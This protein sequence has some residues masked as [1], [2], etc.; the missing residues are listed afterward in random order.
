[1]ETSKLQQS[2]LGCLLGT[3]VSDALG[4]PYEGLNPR[5]AARIFGSPDR[6]HFF[7]GRGMV[8][9][10][11]E[12]ACFTAK[13]LIASRIDPVGFERSLARSLRWWLASIPAGVG[14]ATAMAIFKMWVGFGPDKSGVFSAGNGPAMRSP[15]L[16]VVF[17]DNSELMKDYVKRSTRLTH[18]DPKAY[19]GALCAAMAAAISAKGKQV[20]PSEFFSSIQNLYSPE[21][22]DNFISLIKQACQSAENNDLPPKSAAPM[23]L[24]AI[25]CIPFPV[26]FKHGCAISRIFRVAFRKS[27]RREATRIRLR[28]F[29]A[30]SSA[31]ESESKAFLQNGSLVFGNGQE[32]WIGWKSSLRH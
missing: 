22:A 12:H 28:L 13:A 11:T 7:F 8:S 26:S 29:W 2:I 5:R 20:L 15:L 25:F 14:K 23:A 21:S 27:S 1:L 4:L 32:Q 17:A 6:H 16:G 3:A 10:D 30:A 24:P 18:S 9:D 19:W 31:L